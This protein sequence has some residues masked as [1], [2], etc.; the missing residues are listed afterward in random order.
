MK[1]YYPTFLLL[2]FFSFSQAQ[3]VNIPDANFKNALL[4][5]NPVI[6][7]NGDNEIQES[8]A[9]AVTSLTISNNNISNLEGIQSFTNLQSLQCQNN[10][11]VS[12]DLLSANSN[13]Q[14]LYCSSNNLSNLD[15]S[16]NTN[17][18]DVLIDFNDNIRHTISY[19]S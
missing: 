9:L 11:I 15:L 18:N 5:Y 4:N 7:T 12:L 17:L 16:L 8:E 13:L 14:L 6:D 19:K 2:C 10:Q 3:I 1:K